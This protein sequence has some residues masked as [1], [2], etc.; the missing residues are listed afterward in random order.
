V[1]L[2]FRQGLNLA[3]YGKLTF[4]LRWS[5]IQ[6]QKRIE[7]DGTTFEFAGTH[8]NCD[9]TNCM[10]TPKDRINASLT[11]DVGDWRWAALFNYRGYLKNVAFYGDACANSF[12]DGTDAPP[13][14]KLK[15]FYTVDLSSRW[16]VHKNMEIFGSIQNLFDKV[17]P[18]D[19][20]TY[21]AISYNPLD[22][23]GAVGR[24]YNLGLRYQFN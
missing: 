19:P 2:D 16:R 5:H 10:G 15:A 7:P 21:G 22:I 9:V 6:S 8:G 20:L 11:W 3:E 4:D 1:D 23:S 12:A 14:C 18:L 17:A 24:F 13:G